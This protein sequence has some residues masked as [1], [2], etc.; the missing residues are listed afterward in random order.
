M[1][2]ALLVL[3]LV[4]SAFT[5][6]LEVSGAKIVDGYILVYG[7]TILDGRRI[8]VLVELSER[9]EP[10][11]SLAVDVGYDGAFLDA[12]KTGDGGL[13]AV[14]YVRGALGARSILVTRVGADGRVEWAKA[15]GGE[16]SDYG[17]CVVAL[18]GGYAVL[19]VTRSYSMVGG[20]DL[21]YVVVDEEG[22]VV[23]AKVFGIPAYED[24]VEKVYVLDGRLLAVGTTWSYNVS[25]SDALLVELSERG[26]VLDAATL[27]GADVDEGYAAVLSR[28]GVV[29]VGSTYGSEMGLSDAYVAL[30]RGEEA[31]Y[32]VSMGWERHD[33][34]VDVKVLD[35]SYLTL[36][37]A[38]IG[39]KQV[40]LL[41]LFNESRLLK[42][43]TLTCEKELTPLALGR[44]GSD[45]MVMFRSDNALLTVTLGDRLEPI[46]AFALGN[47]SGLERVELAE[48]RN[49]GRRVGRIES[50]WFVRPHKLEQYPVELLEATLKFRVIRLE[51][52]TKKLE[53]STVVLEER[54]N[55]LMTVVEALE[56]NIPLVILVAPLVV[57]AI[58]W[59]LFKM[60]RH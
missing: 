17:K 7:S 45:I 39:G 60:R 21:V 15:L 34:F 54:E 56:R 58:A 25:I 10:L 13:I 53:L 24:F 27:G 47:V 19:G 5:A 30:M 42:A 23:S 6:Q 11:L 50:A 57:L 2:H 36:G 16:V 35:G 20:T 14:G 9:W 12:A 40:G 18:G 1:A 44:V 33:G 31:S 49:I 43:Y 29:V 8:P 51:L 59:V 32:V 55:P 22:R 26:E 48:L 3:L 52:S 46:Q 4:S 41:T 38:F 28:S 37:Y